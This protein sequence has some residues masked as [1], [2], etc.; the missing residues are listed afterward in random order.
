MLRTIEALKFAF[1][2]KK[3][4]SERGGRKW[5][6]E[7]RELIFKNHHEKELENFE[8]YMPNQ[9]EKMTRS[10]KSKFVRR[11]EKVITARYQLL[12]LYKTVRAPRYNTT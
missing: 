10:L 9:K 8:I 6:T 4:L 12:E 7:Y 11:H 5:K 2:W 1:E 3:K